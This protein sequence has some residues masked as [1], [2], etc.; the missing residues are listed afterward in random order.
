MIKHI[1]KDGTELNSIAG[2]VIY[3]DDFKRVYQIIERMEQRSQ[4]EKGVE[5]F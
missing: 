3:A 2:R 1:L 5:K 4:K